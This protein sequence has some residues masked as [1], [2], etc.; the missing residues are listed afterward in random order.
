M[1][2]LQR[3]DMNK[4]WLSELHYNLDNLV[5]RTKESVAKK[6]AVSLGYVGNIIDVWE[7][8]D[9][10]NIVPELGSDQTSL[11]NPWLGGYTPHGMNYG[12]MKQMISQDPN[13]F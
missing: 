3:K 13:K 12:E 6:E 10:E 4:G 7:K 2:M 5:S 8:L 11:H 1:T 9:S